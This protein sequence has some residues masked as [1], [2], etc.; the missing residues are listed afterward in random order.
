MLL[1]VWKAA[2]LT[3]GK[4][5]NNFTM[6]RGSF[7]YRQ[8][9]HTR[10]KLVKDGIE[11]LSD[12]FNLLFHDDRN[13]VYKL[14]VVEKQ[15]K[16]HVDLRSEDKEWN[17]Y[18]ISIPAVKNEHIYGCGE[19]YS[20]FDL[21]GKKVRIWV[22]EH[23]N[24]LRISDKIIREKIAGK[25]PDFKLP[26]R[27]YE[28]YYVQPTF[29]STRGFYLHA[30]CHRYA[31]FDFRNPDMIV[32]HLQETHSFV[33]E[34]ASGYSELSEKLSSLLGRQKELPD[35]IYDGAI[36]AMQ[37]GTEVLEEKL[38]K[39][40]SSGIKVCGIWSQD[41]CGCRRTGFGYQVM[42]N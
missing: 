2:E 34:E 11:Q 16:V 6:N 3:I 17:R 37:G 36:L 14:K 42:W 26:F 8:R 10:K 13:A 20:E 33:C 22:A 35:W 24:A 39:A 9:I 38:E 18:W 21:K 30:D 1:D 5:R 12:G 41:W 28:S 32:L 40:F 25:R 27:R 15:G 7:R 31:E 29:V 4:G 19:T 23:Q